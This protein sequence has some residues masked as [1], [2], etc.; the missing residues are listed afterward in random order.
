MRW[1]VQQYISAVTS[2]S[3]A[4]YAA[5]D[6][7]I[8]DFTLGDAEM[9][10]LSAIQSAPPVAAKTDDDD[11]DDDDD[12][13]IC[14]SLARAPLGAP[15]APL[16]HPITITPQSSDHVWRLSLVARWLCR[17]R[18]NSRRSAVCDGIGSYL[19]TSTCSGS[20]TRLR[21]RLVFM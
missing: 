3:K 19:S 6:L 1:I 10:R 5:E 11:D 18:L 7:A 9:Q 20:T 2:A 17:L 15:S 21:N 13:C 14:G 8:F 16:H 12:G 4:I